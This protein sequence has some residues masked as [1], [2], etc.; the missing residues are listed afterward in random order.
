MVSNYFASNIPLFAVAVVMILISIRNIRVRKKESIYF[1]VFTGILLFLSVVVLVEQYA[2]ENGLV[3]LATIFTSLGYSTRP[4]LLLIFI[5]LANM[6]EKRS[7][8]F[9]RI[10]ISLLVINVIIYILPWFFNV[11]GV[12]KAV[13]YYELVGGKAIFNYGT[14]VLNYSSHIISLGYL[15][16]LAYLS[17]VR[18]QGKHRRDGLVLILCALIILSAVVT[19]MVLHRTDLLNISSGICIMIDYIFIV[20][21]NFSRDPLTNLYDRRTYYEDITKFKNIINGYIVIDMNELKYFNDNFGHEV[22]DDALKTL[23]GIFSNSINPATM[24]AYRLSGDEFLILMFQGKKEQ[25]DTTLSKIKE[26]LAHCKYSAALGCYFVEKGENITFDEA[27]KKA[28]KLMYED[29][30]KYYVQSGH[31]RRGR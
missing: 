3:Y 19:E 5:I 14:T 7:P 10:F 18:F 28:E 13:F 29:K 16:V 12:S 31:D 4:I 6:D 21:I 17:I 11:P 1:L 26:Q 22:G 20:S 23:A 24:C 27:I 9:F 25:L 8:W 30:N 15:L 2:F